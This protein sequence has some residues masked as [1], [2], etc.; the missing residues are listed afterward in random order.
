MPKSAAPGS[1]HRQVCV[2]ARTD[3][4]GYLV[5]HRT[6]SEGAAV[7]NLLLGV[8][9]FYHAT[10]GLQS[11][12]PFAQSQLRRR[13]GLFLLYYLYLYLLV[14]CVRVPGAWDF[15]QPD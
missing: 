13:S 4:K 1:R 11:I 8:V 15:S 10:I 3:D 6:G 5:R 9:L 14:C 12:Y 7:A 2:L